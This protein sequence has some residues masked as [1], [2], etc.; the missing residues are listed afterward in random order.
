MVRFASCLLLTTSLFLAIAPGL[1]RAAEKPYVPDLGDFMGMTQLRHFKLFY[2]GRT[3]NWDLADYEIGQIR[4]SFEYAAEFYPKL[5]DVDMAKM[6]ETDS[7]GPL[8]SLRQAVASRDP[9]AFS[10]QFDKLTAACN[11]CHEATRFGFIKIGVPT[12]SP[13]TNQMFGPPPK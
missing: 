3:Q 11:A 13:F 2:A 4:K 6:I 12:A 7:F 9:K 10:A 1:G 5:G 8:D